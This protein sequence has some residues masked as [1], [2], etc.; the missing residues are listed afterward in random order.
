MG[1]GWVESAPKPHLYPAFPQ[2][3]SC[4]LYIQSGFSPESTPLLIR[5]GLRH[6]LKERWCKFHCDHFN[7]PHRHILVQS[8]S[9]EV[10][11]GEFWKEPWKT[12]RKSRRQSFS[13]NEATTY[14]YCVCVIWPLVIW[15]GKSL[16]TLR[17]KNPYRPAE[18]WLKENPAKAIFGCSDPLCLDWRH[19][20]FPWGI[21]WVRKT[22]KA[23]IRD[24]LSKRDFPRLNLQKTII[25]KIWQIWRSPC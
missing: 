23:A 14:W 2:P 24:C 3:T 17:S 5:I 9:S 25:H 20:K 15:T 21:K 1:W 11:I 10:G 22:I 4:F 7:P 16:W 13:L 19:R 12:K 8:R 6:G 18:D